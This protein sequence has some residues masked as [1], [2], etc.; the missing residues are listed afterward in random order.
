MPAC[1]GCGRWYDNPAYVVPAEATNTED[2]GPYKD[3]T[4]EGR[5]LIPVCP[6]CFR[7][8]G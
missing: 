2:L 3:A 8:T 7:F 6:Y 4:Q 1:P 5:I